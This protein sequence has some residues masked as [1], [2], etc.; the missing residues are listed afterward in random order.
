MELLCIQTNSQKAVLAGIC[1]PLISDKSPCNCT[2]VIDVGISFYN[3]PSYG[4]GKNKCCTGC[5]K[6]Y[7]EDGIWW[8]SSKLFIGIATKEEVQQKEQQLELQI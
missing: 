4:G 3:S 7:K 6:V 5:G 1:Y 2:D 8:I